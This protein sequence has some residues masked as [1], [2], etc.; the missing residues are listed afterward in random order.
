MKLRIFPPEGLIEDAVVAL[1]LS[2]SMGMRALLLSA[3]ASPSAPL[4][5]EGVAVCDDT[6][7]LRA[8]LEAC[9]A[10]PSEGGSLEADVMAS[11]AALRFLTAFFASRPGVTAVLRGTDRLHERPMAVLVDALRQCGASIEYLGTEGFA[12]LRITGKELEGGAVTVDATVSSQFISALLMVAPLMRRGLELRFDGE[13]VSL[14]YITMTLG[15]MRRRGIDADREPLRITVQPGAYATCD[16]ES[17]GDWSAAAFWYEISALSSGWI[18]L[19]NLSADSLQGDSA[20]A[21]FFSCLGVETAPSDDDDAT[22]LELAPSPEV[23]GRLDLDLTHNPD[24]APPLAATACLIGVP[25][26]LTGLKNL[27]AKECDRLEAIR[28]ELSRL[29]RVVEKIRD[30]GLEWD[31]ASVPVTSVPEFDCHGD[32]RMAMALAP[33]AVYIPGITIEGAEAVSKS[34][35]EF[36]NDLRAVGF[37]VEPVT[38]DETS[39]GEEDRR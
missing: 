38:E 24:L 25:F 23:Y 36:W 5:R 6:A 34:Y 11:G 28:L 15:M 31:G 33:A 26:R 7:A 30:F 2:K 10:L 12:P 32:H 17:E 8:A 18:R 37:S 13:P 29:G 4:P 14:P 21:R 20:A 19:A 39:A 35:P 9:R 22:G 16:P 1:P 27:G 3:L